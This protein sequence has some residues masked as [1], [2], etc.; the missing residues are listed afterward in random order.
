MIP[1]DRKRVTTDLLH[2]HMDPFYN[3]C[4]AYGRLIDAKLNGKLAV[5]CHGYMTLPAAMED[6]LQRRFMI[7]TWDRPTDDQEKPV[8]KREPLRAIVKNLVR[9]NAAFEKK[10]IKKMLVNL[11]RLLKLGIYPLDVN[12]RNYRGGILLDF[13]I[14]ITEPHYLF[15]TRPKWQ[16]DR[17]KREDLLLF[18]R[19]I[20]DANINTQVRAMPNDMYRERLRRA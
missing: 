15:E 17:Y 2:A 12:S 7:T 4:R 11:K 9:E 14:A 16:V 8:S 10:D 6:E 1:E 5:H 18:D 20:E 13:S 19:M 3:E